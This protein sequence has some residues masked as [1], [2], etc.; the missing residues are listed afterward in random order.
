MKLS[1]ALVS[2]CEGYL[3]T[4]TCVNDNH[5]YS[6]WLLNVLSTDLSRNIRFSISNPPIVSYLEICRLYALFKFLIK[7]HERK[8]NNKTTKTKRIH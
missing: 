2:V 8:N 1:F 4:E 3:E 6:V 7:S 5:V